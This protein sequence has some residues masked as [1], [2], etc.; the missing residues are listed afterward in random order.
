MCLYRAPNEDV[1]FARVPTKNLS[2]FCPVEITV[3]IARDLNK[4]QPQPSSTSINLPLSPA[5]AIDRIACCILCGG[6]RLVATAF[7]QIPGVSSTK[8]LDPPHIADLQSTLSASIAGFTKLLLRPYV[9]WFSVSS[10]SIL[11]CLRCWSRI[12]SALTLGVVNLN[13]RSRQPQS[14][15]HLQPCRSLATCSL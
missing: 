10:T 6:S 4:P 12:S 2:S 14:R 15:P 5:A 9:Y 8:R 7:G 1:H 11:G 13:F 3:V